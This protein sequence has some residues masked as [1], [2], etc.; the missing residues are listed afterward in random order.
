MLLQ[1]NILFWVWH[2]W[3]MNMHRREG[4]K[5]GEMH[6]PWDGKRSQWRRRLQ[7]RQWRLVGEEWPRQMNKLREQGRREVCGIWLAAPASLLPSHQQQSLFWG[8]DNRHTGEKSRSHS[9]WDKMQHLVQSVKLNP[10]TAAC[11]FRYSVKVCMVTLGC[12]S[13]AGARLP[14]GPCGTSP[15]EELLAD[16]CSCTPMSL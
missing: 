4:K 16:E 12:S 7:P 10:T 11:V 6:L 2:S 1:S 15:E 13:W 9:H 3:H 5:E 8:H 14:A